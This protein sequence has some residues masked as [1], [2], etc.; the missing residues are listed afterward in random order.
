MTL[1]LMTLAEVPRCGLVPPKYDHQ[2]TRAVWVELAEL[3]PQNPDVRAQTV[4]DGLD[5]TRRARGVLTRWWR[6]LR[7][8]SWAWSI[9]RS[10]T[11][12]AG[13]AP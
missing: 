7:G 4:V 9:T 11:S 5:L 2:L 3:F 12:T 13:N 10:I 6:G 8:S 1:T